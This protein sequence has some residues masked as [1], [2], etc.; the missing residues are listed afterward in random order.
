VVFADSRVS[1]RAPPALHL[2]WGFRFIARVE[3]A[4]T[5]R[6]LA[7]ILFRTVLDRA[8]FVVWCVAFIMQLVRVQF[9]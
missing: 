4:V 2:A 8:L 1:G 7:I 6:I 9:P 5:G 3:W